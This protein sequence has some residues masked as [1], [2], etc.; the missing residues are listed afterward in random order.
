MHIESGTNPEIKAFA[1]K[2]GFEGMLMGK[3]D[4]NSS[5]T[6]L[7]SVKCCCKGDALLEGMT[8]MKNCA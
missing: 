7:P 8:F 5:F 2:K 3:I 6:L 4:V 1:A